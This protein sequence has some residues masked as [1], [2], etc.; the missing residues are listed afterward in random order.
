MGWTA[1]AVRGGRYTLRSM[2]LAQRLGGSGDMGGEFEGDRSSEPPIVGSAAGDG[3]ADEQQE[4]LD[5]FA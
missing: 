1:R 2:V 5:V 3:S 4:E